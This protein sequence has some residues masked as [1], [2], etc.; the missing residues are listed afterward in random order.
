[1]GLLQSIARGGT[2]LDVGCGTGALAER[3]QEVGFE[4]VGLDASMAMLNLLRERSDLPAIC[5]KSS[6]LPFRDGSFNHVLCVAS[7]HHVAERS[8]VA[9]PVREMSGVER[10]GGSVVLVVL[11]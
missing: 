6:R 9:E 7:L 10:P 2:L 1:V 4:A 8:A 3:L 11:L 5:G